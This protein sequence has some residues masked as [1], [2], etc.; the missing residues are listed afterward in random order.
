MSHELLTTTEL[1]NRTGINEATWRHWFRIGL[2]PSVKMG[3]RV[4][5]TEKDFQDFITENRQP[6]KNQKAE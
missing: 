4:L 5:I 1:K 2:L 3:K 6:A